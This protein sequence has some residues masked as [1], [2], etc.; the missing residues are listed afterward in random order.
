ML[1]GELRRAG[2]HEM[3]AAGLCIT[4]AREANSGSYLSFTEKRDEHPFLVSINLDLADNVQS[5]R[6]DDDLQKKFRS[7]PVFEA[8]VAHGAIQIVLE[9][10]LVLQLCSDTCEGI[11]ICRTRFVRRA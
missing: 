7:I 1:F 11:D 2:I 10:V 3:S 6:H 8:Y 5:R 9:M 4:W